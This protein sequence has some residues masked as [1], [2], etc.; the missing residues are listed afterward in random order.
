MITLERWRSIMDPVNWGHYAR[1]AEDIENNYKQTLGEISDFWE[2]EII[3][4]RSKVL[5]IG[6]GNGRMGMVLK[7]YPISQYVGIDPHAKSIEFCSNTLCEDE[8]FSFK[9]IDLRNAQYNPKGKMKPT[10]FTIPFEDGSFDSVICCSLFSHIETLKVATR[11]LQEIERVLKPGGRF[12]SSWFRS[13]PNKLTKS[14]FRTVL[15]EKD[16]QKLFKP[17]HIYNERGGT[18]EDFNDQWCIYAE[19]V[20]G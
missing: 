19:K 1:T 5:D 15:K 4:E 3:R 10:K 18:S 11:Y 6:S 20:N 14:A 17:F 13:P 7:S 9:W 16:I 2:K 8:R 12:F